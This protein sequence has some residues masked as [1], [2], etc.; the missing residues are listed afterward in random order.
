MR[1]SFTISRSGLLL[2]IVGLIAGC[3][4]SSNGKDAA[5]D[6]ATDMAGGDQGGE[7]DAQTEMAPDMAPDMAKMCLESPR[8]AGGEVKLDRR[9]TAECSPYLITTNITVG[10][11]AVLTIDPGVEVRFASDT[12][13]DVGY[14]GDGKLV[15]EGTVMAPIRLTGSAMPLAPGNWVGVFLENGTLAGTSLKNLVLE[16]AGAKMASGQGCLTISA[17]TGR[18]SVESVTFNQCGQAG[19]AVDELDFDFTVFATNKFT[20]I[21]GPGI[22]V[23][24]TTLGS[25]GAGHMFE[26]AGY[27]RLRGATVRK[28][29][30]WRSMGVPWRVIESVTIGDNTASPV[31]TIEAGAEFA[32]ASDTYFDVGYSGAGGLIATGTADKKIR[33]VTSSASPSPASWEGIFLE[34]PV[35][36]GTVLEHV[37]VQY[38]GA[39]S[40]G[41]NGCINIRGVEP[42]RV[43][44]ANAAVGH[45]G[46]N[47]I[48]IDGEKSVV[49]IS[50][51]TFEDI[52]VTGHAISLPCATVH[53]LGSGNVY[54]GGTRNEILGGTIKNT[55]TWVTQGTPFDV[56]ASVTVGDNTASPVLTLEPNT[57]RFAADTYL[58][59]GYTGAGK[60]VAAGLPAQH[61][62]FTAANGAKGGWHGLFFEGTIVA[63][64]KLE[65][66]DVT[67]G[68]GS[69]AG[70]RGNISFING[71]TTAVAITSAKIESSDQYGIWVDAGSM[72]P[73]LSDVS[74]ADNT[75]GDTYCEAAAGACP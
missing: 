31:V 11:G 36:A 29:A 12:Y 25:I 53:G 2:S 33:F 55:A 43:K 23:R 37:V 13:L 63:G 30:T 46:Q 73:T 56:N 70:S 61:V 26:V 45:C 54:L 69:G 47:G 21:M 6:V 41:S 15:A 1:L 65:N 27:N 34:G 67:H 68:G 71:V 57:F 50:N 17:K 22:D 48:D 7:K 64:S 9:L 32:F 60:L 66:V 39:M 49:A 38:G 44:I 10:D 16:G 51:T 59:V 18:V 28:A 5:P 52:A 4:G 72:A 19:V 42:G 62:V 40:S 58:D 14:S 24:A 3:G 74:Y 8:F 75:D 35:L 20:A